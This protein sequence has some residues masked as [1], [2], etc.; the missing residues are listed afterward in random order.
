MPFWEHN[1][2]LLK[3]FFNQFKN[4]T[5][6]EFYKGIN[7]VTPSLIRTEADELTYHFH[8][9]I[10]YEIEK[11]L[12]NGDIQTKDIPAYWN[13]QYEKYLNI[14]VPDDKRGCLQDVHWSHGSFGYFATYSLGSMYAAQLYAAMQKENILIQQKITERDIETIHQWLSKK[15]YQHGRYFTSEELFFHATGESLNEDY[16]IEYAIKKYTTIYS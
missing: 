11:M 14:K 9:M 16:F 12:I 2:L 4:I 8:I 15:I 7:K 1:F 3:S 5:P 13:E 6:E 10:R